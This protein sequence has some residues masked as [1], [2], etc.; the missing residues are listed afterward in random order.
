LIYTGTKPYKV[1]LIKCEKE[2]IDWESKANGGHVYTRPVYTNAV[3]SMYLVDEQ[4][5][6]G[7]RS[8]LSNKNYDSNEVQLKPIGTKKIPYSKTIYQSEYT[9]R[10]YPYL[11]DKEKNSWLM[12]LSGCNSEWNIVNLSY[13]PLTEKASLNLMPKELFFESDDNRDLYAT[14]FYP[15]AYLTF[16]DGNFINIDNYNRL[17]ILM[18]G[19]DCRYLANFRFVGRDK[20]VKLFFDDEGI[21]YGLRDKPPLNSIKTGYKYDTSYN[22]FVPLEISPA[23]DKAAWIDNGKE[24]KLLRIWAFE[25]EKTTDIPLIQ[26]PTNT[27][28]TIKWNPNPH[29]GIIAIL[30]ISKILIINTKNK[31]II[32][33]FDNNASSLMHW[34]PDGSKLGFM[35]ENQLGIYDMKTK[36]VKTLNIG[37]KGYN[38]TW[39]R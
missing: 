20:I 28:D 11:F 12:L 38:F 10:E 8:I 31:E 19:K 39:V 25:S 15:P 33:R 26:Y 32:N 4:F 30:T 13:N 37:P 34:S 35:S 36:T 9:I 23:Q 18:N 7:K 27:L 5:V 22:N 16:N 14:G 6:N 3:F 2:K 29:S 24:T 17:I 21:E 1:M